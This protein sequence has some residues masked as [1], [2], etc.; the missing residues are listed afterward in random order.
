VTPWLALW[1]LH[2]LGLPT[3]PCHDS[4]ALAG[5]LGLQ[6]LAPGAPAWRS[7]ALRLDWHEHNWYSSLTIPSIERALQTRALDHFVAS[8]ADAAR[9][10]IAAGR[11]YG[12]APCEAQR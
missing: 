1:P 10:A 5:T 12:R 9:A 6:G 3:A 11:W 7:A 2:A 8:L 4:V